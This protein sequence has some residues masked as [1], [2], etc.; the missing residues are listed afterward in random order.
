L[1]GL[2]IL[3]LASVTILLISI[4][5]DDE[6]E[7]I[8]EL[9]DDETEVIDELTDDETE[10]IVELIDD[11]TEVIVELIDD[12]NELVAAAIDD[13]TNAGVANPEPDEILMLPVRLTSP[14]AFK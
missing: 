14:L 6:T 8:V 5:A 7:V 10:V 13:V 12:D 4:A 2:T 3:L 1:F 11:E 9:T